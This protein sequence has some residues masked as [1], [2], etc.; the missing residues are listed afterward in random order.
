MDSSFSA[1]QKQLLCL[2]RAL[3][4]RNRFL[5]LDEATSNIDFAT[6]QK[7]QQCIRENFREVTVVAIAHRL[8]TIQDYDKILV[9]DAGHSVE[10]GTPQQLFSDKQGLFRQMVE[11]S[12]AAKAKKA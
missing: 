10:F 11:A 3:L 1:G 4:S 5:V 7:I 6:D 2:T 9:M 8:Q 12:E